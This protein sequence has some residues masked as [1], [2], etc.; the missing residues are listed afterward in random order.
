MASTFPGS[1][2]NIQ[3]NVANSTA[4]LDTHPNLHNKL[5]D[6][7]NAVETALLPGGTMNLAAHVAAADPHTIYLTQTEGDARYS[8]IAGGGTVPDG[9]VTLAKLAA[10]SVDSSKIVDGT[11][12]T[13]DLK[14][15]SVTSA[16][17]LDG[18]IATADLA[19]ASVTNAKLA[20]DT[21]RANQLANPSFD[22]WQRGNGPF[23]AQNSWTAD[24]WQNGVQGTDT[25]SVSADVAN[26][27]IGSAVAA[28]CTFTL[29]SGGGT[30]NL[31]QPLGGESARF[32]SR[33]FSL[34]IRVRT[35]TANAVRISFYNGSA[36]NYSSFHTGSGTYETLTATATVTSNATIVNA[37]V[38]FAASC[39]A[40]LDNAMLVVGS[41]P[42]DYAPLH[43]ADDLA[44]CL[45]YYEIV[46]ETPGAMALTSYTSAGAQ[47]PSFFIPLKV[48]KAVLPT[49]TKNGTWAVGNA[50]QPSIGGGSGLDGFPFYFASL[51]AG[52]AT[53]ANNSVGQTITAEANP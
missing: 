2:D 49:L 6:A 38:F 13:A 30:S 5:A 35:N 28:A 25:L 29:G 22:I 39:T 14:D 37:V 24:R 41:V 43:P 33:T 11:I 3:N 1:A 27:D 26:V 8:T 16:K 40:Y 47:S 46:G 32:R 53:V 17:I 52:M 20:S 4:E 9:S 45:R 51:A 18:T 10:N 15:S 12:D 31:V 23:T 48:R 19:N 36:H 50:G 34:S 7:V 21:A 42:A 44:R